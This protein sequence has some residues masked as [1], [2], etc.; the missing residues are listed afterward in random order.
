MQDKVGSEI[1]TTDQITQ[2]VAD[3]K[4]I[5]DRIV[6]YTV[7]LSA[8]ERASTLKMRTGGEPIVAA[9]AKLANDH[10]ITLPQITVDGMLADLTLAKQIRPL[11]SAV[12][13]LNQRLND[14]VLEAQSECWWAATALYT[15][16]VRASGGDPVLEAALK[17]VI[18]FFARGKRK[19]AA[20]AAK[21]I[22]K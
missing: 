3:L 2:L 11:A 20:A 7:T 13:Q 12:A 5:S 10:G 4:S 8:D 15:S 19:K 16:L 1:P 14:T 9:I 18:D 17:P 22:V 21:K 6:A